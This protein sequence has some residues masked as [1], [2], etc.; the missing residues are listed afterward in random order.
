MSP[1]PDFFAP[2]KFFISIQRVILVFAAVLS[3][4]FIVRLLH[5]QC[6][7]KFELQGAYLWHAR[8]P[9]PD[10]WIHLRVV[11]TLVSEQADCAFAAVCREGLPSSHGVAVGMHIHQRSGLQVLF[12]ACG[13]A[14]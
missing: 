8:I 6:V 11:L 1:E 12:P 4:W 3:D 9:G 14:L 2:I 7:A 13:G 5:A 10:C